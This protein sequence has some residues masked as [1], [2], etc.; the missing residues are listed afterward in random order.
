MN[1][2]EKPHFSYPAN[3]HVLDLATLVSMYRERGAPQKA[4][5]GE[6]FACALTNQLIKEGK[7]WF[8]RYYSQQAW[9]DLLTKSCEGY[10]LTEVEMNILGLA[11]TADEE[12]QKRDYV[13]ENCGAIA[14]L[15][16]MIV[17]DLKEF[18]FLSIDDMD[19]IM[20]TPR[21]EKALQGIAHRIY[22]KKF[23]AGMLY[24][25]KNDVIRPTIERASKKESEQTRL[26]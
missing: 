22:Q 15:A 20:I 8:G 12:P 3:L 7:W 6:Y 9:N 2:K 18:G 11:S 23:N 10:P 17:N 5:P 19:R 21:G 14:K 13:E 24:A 26:F 25:N 4:K 1:K 16:F